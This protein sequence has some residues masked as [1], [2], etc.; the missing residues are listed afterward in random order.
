MLEIKHQSVT[1][2]SGDVVAVIIDI[3]TF[4]RME[5]I[6]EDYGLVHF[7]KEAESDETLS[8]EDAIEYLRTV[9]EGPENG[10]VRI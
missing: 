7:M 1:S 9:E 5:A 3:A 6:I 2:E 10:S 8:R 4:R